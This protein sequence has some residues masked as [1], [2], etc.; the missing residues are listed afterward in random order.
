MAG[1]SSGH[2]FTLI[3]R[4]GGHQVSNVDKLKAAAGAPG[5]QTLDALRPRRAASAPAVVA[6]DQEVIAQ[7]A[8][9]AALRASKDAIRA[10]LAAE[11]S[12]KLLRKECRSAEQHHA[13]TSS[14][15]EG[16]RLGRLAP[17]ASEAEAGLLVYHFLVL[18][19]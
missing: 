18:S 3:P 17:L 19:V 14:L 2:N 9:D 11:I 1:R 4:S 7:E 5:Q 16:L 10:V 6:V 8:C 13:A 15:L 12:L